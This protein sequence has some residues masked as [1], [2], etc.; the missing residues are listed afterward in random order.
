MTQMELAKRAGIS[1]ETLNR[2]EHGK[3][4]PSVPTIAKIDRALKAAEKDVR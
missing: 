3:N 1:Q 2:I 4:Q